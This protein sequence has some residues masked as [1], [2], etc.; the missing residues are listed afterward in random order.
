MSLTFLRVKE[1]LGAIPTMH[2]R[3]T[4]DNINNAVIH[5]VRKLQQL[6][7]PHQS[8]RNGYAGKILGTAE[9]ALLANQA[10]KDWPYPGPHHTF[11]KGAASKI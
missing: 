1:H 9:Y 8:T 5:L 10:W 7:A 3:P 2:P 4:S 11:P 6:P